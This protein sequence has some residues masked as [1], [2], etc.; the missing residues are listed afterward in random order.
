MEIEIFLR[1]FLKLEVSVDFRLRF[2]KKLWV[3]R[4]PEPLQMHISNFFE[5]VTK[6]FA[7]ISKN[8]KFS[9]KIFKKL[10]V[11]I[12]FS[13]KILINSL[14]SRGFAPEPPTNAYF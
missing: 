14:A 13:T 8:G 11:S 10:Q 5:I 9:I 12:D 6:I 7:K 2:W 3:L 4:F 1:N